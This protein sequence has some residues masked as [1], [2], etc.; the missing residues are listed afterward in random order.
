MDV[1]LALPAMTEKMRS[2]ADRVLNDEFFLR[3]ET[4]G[5]FESEFAKFVE[6]EH[7][8][9]V[10][11]GTQAIHLS[12][13]AAGIGEGDTVIT[14]PATFIATANSIQRT[15]AE[16]K[17]VDVD[18]DTYTID[19]EKLETAVEE[20]EN[21]SAIIPV[22]LYGYPVD[23][24]KIRN[25]APDA[26][27]ISDACQAHGASIRGKKVGTM[28]DLTA[29][30]FYPSKNMTVGGDGGMITTNSRELSEAARSFADVGRSIGE[31][32]YEHERIGYTARMDTY[33]AA[34]GKE[35]LKHLPEW[36]ERR[37]D[38]AEKYTSAFDTL[39]EVDLPPSGN[40]EITPAWYFYVIRTN[41]RD[42][43]SEYLENKGIE[44][45]VHYPTPV[46]LQPPYRDLGY[47]EGDFPRSEQWANEVLSLP[48]HPHLTDEQVN[49]VISNVNSFFN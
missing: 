15:G 29:F 21:L 39:D 40:E 32:E 23:I 42:E 31:G 7:A 30:S 2:E 14:T 38:I 47:E 49:H 48:V 3:G 4:V 46:H 35:Q 41:R 18:L 9:A 27:I 44:T 13:K 1:P 45:G 5:T 16:V 34:I 28:A 22:D 19:L 25:I 17:F 6:A 36:N 33:K 12:L 20:I 8:V 43:L 37:T 11:S 10:S 26:T 24:E